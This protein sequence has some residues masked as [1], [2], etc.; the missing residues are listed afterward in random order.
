M[1]AR[2]ELRARNFFLHSY[3]PAKLNQSPFLDVGKACE[4]FRQ[5]QL[6]LAGQYR[7]PYRFSR[8]KKVIEISMDEHKAHFQN[9][10]NA[11]NFRWM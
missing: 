9:H 5:L 7:Q 1:S 8:F 4:W 10:F 2:V 6:G 11:K 3:V